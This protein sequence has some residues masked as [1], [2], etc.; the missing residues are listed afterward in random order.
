M[1]F[2]NILEGAIKAKLRGS[3]YKFVHVVTHDIFVEIYTR[4][5]KYLMYLVDGLF[6]L[7]DRDVAGE[8]DYYAGNKVLTT[9]GEGWEFQ[10]LNKE[11]DWQVVRFTEG[12]LRLAYIQASGSLRSNSVTK[13]PF[14]PSKQQN[15]YIT[16]RGIEFLQKIMEER[17]ISIFHV[18]NKGENQEY[19]IYAY[20]DY[21]DDEGICIIVYV[22]IGYPEKD[23]N[24][25][26][27]CDDLLFFLK[28]NPVYGTCYISTDFPWVQTPKNLFD[29][30]PQ[31]PDDKWFTID[32]WSAIQIMV[33]DAMAIASSQFV[34]KWESFVTD[35]SNR[36]GLTSNQQKVDSFAKKLLDKLIL[37]FPLS[38]RGEIYRQSIQ[39]MSYPNGI[40][41]FYAGIFVID[42]AI[43]T[44]GLVD[45]GLIVNL[46][47]SDGWDTIW[48]TS[49]SATNADNSYL[50][51]QSN[52][53]VICYDKLSTES[54]VVA[55]EASKIIQA[56]MFRLDEI[57]DTTKEG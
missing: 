48:K 16:K 33:H 14:T 24:Y 29:P 28:I 12:L 43:D 35:N 47:Q 30:R 39:Y 15:Y 4:N 44:C 46:S 40:T 22:Q 8:F 57:L 19:S 37:E 31:V 1:L 21:S 54:R 36:I 6:Y 18:S 52:T 53:S 51:L 34:K 10:P 27:S 26:L 3:E 7:N 20:P 23:D 5:E 9:S 42:V 13:L 50:P 41:R 55:E 2:E 25:P 38:K 56:M 17:L 11:I 45:I 49:Y 32:T